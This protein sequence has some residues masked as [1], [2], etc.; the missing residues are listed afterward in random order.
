MNP[1]Y[2]EK[3]NILTRK[4]SFVF[5]SIIIITFAVYFKILGFQLT[6][7]D[8]KLLLAGSV[9]NQSI[10]SVFSEP[11]IFSDGLFYRP[12]ITLTFFISSL[13]QKESLLLHYLVNIIIHAVSCFFLYVLLLRLKIES[14]PVYFICIIYSVHPVFT[15]AVAWLPG[16][17]DS[18]MA[19]FIFLSMIYLINYTAESKVK[20][21]VLFSLFFTCSLLTKEAA[22]VSVVLF[23][24]YLYLFSKKIFVKKKYDIL[25]AMALPV[26]SWYLLRKN[27]VPE[28]PAVE[29]LQNQLYYLQGLGKVFLPLNLTVLPVIPDTSF[30]YGAVSVLF[31]GI[32]FFIPKVQNVKLFVFGICWF[33]V[34]LFAAVINTNP[35]YSQN[36]M[37]E[38]RLYLPAAGI[39]IAL[40]QTGAVKIFNFKK[41]IFFPVLLL[42]IAVFVYLNFHY[43]AY[44][45]DQ[46]SYWEEAVSSSPSLDLSFAGLGSFYFIKEDYET[47]IENYKKAAEIF[48]IKP[49]Y[50]SKIA[51]SYLKLDKPNDAEIYYTKELAVNP[52]DYDAN[53]LLGV[54]LFK[55]NDFAKAEKYFLAAQKLNPGDVQPVY[56]LVKLY[57][58]AG[59]SEKSQKY[60]EILKSKGIKI[61]EIDSGDKKPGK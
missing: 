54:I 39:F 59:D 4:K 13:I 55:K 2:S 46:K 52:N 28:M 19:L 1:L 41:I 23:L 58:A 14:L 27:A 35:E 60:S 26:F 47:A 43:S 18:L 37:P 11:Y 34:F 32:L 57:N 3:L 49:G 9:K 22:L 15:N 24:L 38:S 17:N 6:G 33:F 36:L 48:P 61:P 12:L 7:S 40:L 29:L 50:N 21:L 56:Y 8:D 51:F 5:L 30:I 16:R 44:Y 20:N 53:L 31:I 25:I 10:I 45:K 42:I